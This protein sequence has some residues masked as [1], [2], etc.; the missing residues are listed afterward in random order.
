MDSYTNEKGEMVVIATMD[1]FR[2]IH[3][4]AKYSEINGRENIVVKSLKAEAIKRLSEKKE[5]NE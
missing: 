1:D 4:I 2:L 5:S 3:A